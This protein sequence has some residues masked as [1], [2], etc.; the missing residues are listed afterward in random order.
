[1]KPI[2]IASYWRRSLYKHEKPTFPY[3]SLVA[4]KKEWHCCNCGRE[5]RI[6]RYYDTGLIACPKCESRFMV[7][8]EEQINYEKYDLSNS[9]LS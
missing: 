3:I 9:G 4:D 2:P 8:V 6:L 5:G 7:T 1:M